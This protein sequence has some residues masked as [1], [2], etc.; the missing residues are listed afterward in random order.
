LHRRAAACFAECDPVLRAAH[1]DRAGDPA[2]A[3]A[4]L[5]AARSQAAAYHNERALHLVER[6]HALAIERPDVCALTQFKGELLHDLGVIPEARQ[7]FQR[8]LEVGGD[9]VER[10]RA[11][12]GLA[13]VMRISDQLQDALQALERA[14][15][16]A[17][18]ENLT[19]ELSRIHHLRGNLYFPLGKIE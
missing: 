16:L 14:Q 15:P 17:A 7:A 11:W 9:D 6:G 10:C 13:A 12:I 2:A 19:V 1:L 3:R 4:Y 8:A 5:S 18:A